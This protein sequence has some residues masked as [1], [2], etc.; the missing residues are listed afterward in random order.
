MAGFAVITAVVGLNL[1]HRVPQHHQA[2]MRSRP[3]SA[4]MLELN[5]P[6]VFIHFQLPQHAVT[7]QVLRQ[8]VYAFRL[9]NG[10]GANVL[11][12]TNLVRDLRA[13]LTSSSVGVIHSARG[14]SSAWTVGTPLAA[15]QHTSM[16]FYH[17]LELIR[18][19]SRFMPEV[20]PIQYS[21]LPMIM[22]SIAAS[23]WLVW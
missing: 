19:A 23:L 20:G 10:A 21:S 4:P 14:V 2:I 13:V 1:Y 6:D 5:Q 12:A 15:L 18:V 22:K 11:P 8:T 9:L 17:P 3:L 16:L 7:D